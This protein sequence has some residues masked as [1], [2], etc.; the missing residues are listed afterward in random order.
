MDIYKKQDAR[1]SYDTDVAEL[2]ASMGLYHVY[3]KNYSAALGLLKKS[4]CVVRGKMEQD[5]E[6]AYFY[7]NTLS[8]YIKALYDRAVGN[9]TEF[10]NWF[11][12]NFEN[13]SVQ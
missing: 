7:E 11:N 3:F 2:Y 9:E 5:T 12:E 1:Y 4:Y 13:E 6:L 10:E 8:L